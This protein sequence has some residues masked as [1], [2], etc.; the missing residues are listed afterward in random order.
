MD[1]L[2]KDHWRNPGVDRVF[3]DSVSSYLRICHIQRRNY[4]ADEHLAEI[5]LSIVSS[6]SEI[7]PLLLTSE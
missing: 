4:E 5:K 1:D 2:S 3:V 6:K 7:D